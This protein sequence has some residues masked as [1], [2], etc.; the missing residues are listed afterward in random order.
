MLVCV[1]IGCSIDGQH[2]IYDV[3]KLTQILLPYHRLGTSISN[4]FFSAQG[5]FYHVQ[6]VWE[7]TQN[8]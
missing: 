7:S 3:N 1:K 4:L 5:K 8:S 6:A 2:E